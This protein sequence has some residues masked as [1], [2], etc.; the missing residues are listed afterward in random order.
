MGRWWQI[1]PLYKHFESPYATVTNN[2]I[3]YVDFLGLDTLR[4]DS[5]GFNWDDVKNDDVVIGPEV[6]DEVVGSTA[7]AP[8]AKKQKKKRGGVHW[9]DPNAN[10][11]GPTDVGQPS[12]E[13]DLPYFMGGYSN[14]GLLNVFSSFLAGWNLAGNIYDFFNEPENKSYEEEEKDIKPKEP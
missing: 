3:R 5:E 7:S 6:M 2:P 13:S 8:K 4:T 14:R 12:H 1:D 10:G 11:P 9:T